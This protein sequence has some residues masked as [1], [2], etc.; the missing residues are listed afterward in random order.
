M[1]KTVAIL[2]PSPAP[3]Q[4]GGAEKLFHGLQNALDKLP[5]VFSEVIKLP[6]REGSFSDLIAAYKSYYELDLS[7]FDMVISTKYPS[8]M[9]QHKNHV[10]Y[11]LHKLRGFY[12]TWWTT[13]MPDE[14]DPVPSGVREL[15]SLVS[16]GVGSREDLPLLFDLCQRA[17]KNRTLP[18]FVFS[19]PGPLLRKIVHFMDRIAL[20]PQNIR[21][22]MAISGTVARRADYFP[23][24]CPV[25]IIYPPSDLERIVQGEEKY[26]LSIG[27][28]HATKRIDLLIEAFS[29]VPGDVRL[30]IVG[31][32]PEEEALK[33]L[34]ANDQRIEFCGFVSDEKRAELYADALFV[35]FI[36]LDEDYGLVTV[37]AMAAG[38]PVITFR[39][40]GGVCEFVRNGMNGFC[41]ETDPGALAEAMTRLAEN[42]ALRQRLG[43]AA[44]RSVANL[45]WPRT[46]VRL[47]EYAEYSP[48]RKLDPE[49]PLVVVCSPYA[50]N[51]AGGGGE[52]RLWHLC[53]SLLADYDVILICVGSRKSRIL[54][55]REE[56]KGF[57]QIVWPWPAN[58]HGL[59]ELIRNR[60]L[61]SVDDVQ[62]MEWCGTDPE[63]LRI[64]SEQTRKASC[65]ILYQPYLYP[66][67]KTLS[68]KIPLIYAAPDVEW[69]VKER[70]LENAP[71]LLKAVREE[72]RECVSEASS[73]IACSEENK[74]RF[75]ELYGVNEIQIS[76]LPNGVDWGDE[77]YTSRAQKYRERKHLPFAW[78]KLAL[79][80]GSG[81]LPNKEAVRNI[82]S[83]APRV[84]DVQFIIA[85]SVSTDLEIERL[86]RPA[87]VHLAGSISESVKKELLA[88]ADL[89][90][91]PVSSGSG[92]NLKI[93][94]YLAAGL[95]CVST[96]FGMRGM[97]REME[98]AVRICEVEDFPQGITE[99]LAHPPAPE[100][101][102]DVARHVRERSCWSSVMAKS[103]S[104]IA[105]ALERGSRLAADC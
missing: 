36:P 40:S 88:V 65:I 97:D 84:A 42:A 83:M 34:A 7:H 32:G 13:G 105:A 46:A 68:P 66:A 57:T 11:M 8:W 77:L 22:Y 49:K 98:Q 94:E 62:I 99:T 26:I 81:H 30:K 89:A 20:A 96:P 93:V 76:V 15:Y 52:R 18:P 55:I 16:K 60:D 9:S 28:L 27:R 75:Q 100:V 101:L 61:A 63:F 33:K 56:K 23:P 24:G 59:S 72:E 82:F 80:I 35:P 45:N 37:E 78:A 90:I 102:A 58:G 17:L 25:E 71:E 12:D 92:T 29:R 14:L 54:E 87:N 31:T 3:Y 4:L 43:E 6:C 74:S 103:R 38:K 104:L 85:G 67:L 5:G 47:M 91:N 64:L 70:I 48:L 95:P 69:D 51:R 19:H 1:S 10:V 21:A 86:K 50:A 44:R 53:D 41:V 73:L 2:A 79:F 39:D